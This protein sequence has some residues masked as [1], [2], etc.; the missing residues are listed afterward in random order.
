MF[1]T[2]NPAYYRDI[3]FR[4]W[5]RV[6][7]TYLLD[8]LQKYGRRILHREHQEMY[9]DLRQFVNWHKDSLLWKLF[10]K[11][12][13]IAARPAPEAARETV[14]MFTAIG[15]EYSPKPYPGRIHLFRAEGR[16]REFGADTTLG[17]DEIARDGV[18]VHHVPG[19]HVTILDNPHVVTLAKEIERCLVGTPSPT[20][21]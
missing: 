12:S 14:I 9:A 1:D 8:R 13:R 16:T 10:G 17:W 3:P 5:I 20:K 15:R 18:E 21:S 6:R 19:K 2:G 7:S 4:R 11:S